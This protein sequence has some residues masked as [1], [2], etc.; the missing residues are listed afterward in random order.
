M[1]HCRVSRAA[2]RDRLAKVARKCGPAGP[3]RGLGPAWADHESSWAMLP[4]VVLEDE[5]D[6]LY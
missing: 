2:L 4:E 1:E 6:V 3:S 5:A